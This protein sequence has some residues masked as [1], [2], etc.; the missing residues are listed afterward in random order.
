MK[1]HMKNWMILHRVDD[2]EVHPN[3]IGKLCEKKPL[4]FSKIRKGDNI[5]YYCYGDMVIT[6]IFKVV[7]KL[8]TWKGDK[9]WAGGKYWIYRIRPVVKAPSPRYVSIKELLN[10]IGSSLQLFPNGKVEGVRLKGKTAIPVSNSDFRKIKEYIKNYEGKIS[11]D[12]KGASNDEGLGEP[13]DLEVMN[14]APTSEAGVVVLF[15]HFLRE[16]GFEKI[17]FVRAG[18]PDACV[19]EKKG[20]TFHRK[21]VEFEF[22]ASNFKDHVRNQ[23]HRK[24]KCDYVV[25][26]E[27]D[28]KTCPVKVIELK[29]EL[30][31]GARKK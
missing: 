30:E 26:W 8:L 17:E 25:C 20:K 18:F 21:Y 1:G 15:S 28:Y 12:F 31:N 4:L 19:L 9:Y 10:N 5:I 16:L 13:L 11:L 24:L 23:N 29:A 14:Y 6:G 27:N 3:L 7:S 22:L 2:F